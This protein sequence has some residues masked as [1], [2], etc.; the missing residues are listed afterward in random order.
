LQSERSESSAGAENNN[1]VAFLGTGDFEGL[2][3]GNAS[4]LNMSKLANS[5]NTIKGAE[6]RGSMPSGTGVT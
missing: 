2:I 1:I 4:T 3:S 5:D 6:M